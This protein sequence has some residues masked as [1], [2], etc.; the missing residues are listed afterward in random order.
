[1][2]VSFDAEREAIDLRFRAGLDTP[3][4]ERALLERAPQLTGWSFC[5][6]SGPLPEHVITQ[7]DDGQELVLAYPDINF[8]LLPQDAQG[9]RSIIL[10]SATEFDLERQNSH[11]YRYAAREILET[12]LG[13]L[14]SSLRSFALVPPSAA[15]G[16]QPRPLSELVPITSSQ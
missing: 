16:E 3:S 12:V 10:V 11:L 4:L 15:A 8:L 13:P 9:D 5:A 14:P 7:D 2:Q 1:M 6:G